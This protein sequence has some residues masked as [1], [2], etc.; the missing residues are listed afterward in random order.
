MIMYSEKVTFNTTTGIFKQE[1]DYLFSLKMSCRCW[2]L[3]HTEILFL[4]LS[5]ALAEYPSWL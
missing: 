2:L 5:K 3:I 1:L 4:T